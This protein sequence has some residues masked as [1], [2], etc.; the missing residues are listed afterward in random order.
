MIWISRQRLLLRLRGT[1]AEWMTAQ[2]QG[3]TLAMTCMIGR[4]NATTLA[5]GI[6]SSTTN[7]PFSCSAHLRLIRQITGAGS[8]RPLTE[9][10]K[11]RQEFGRIPKKNRR[12][13]GHSGSSKD[14]VINV[15]DQRV[16]NPAVMALM[17]GPG[18]S[19][20][21][22]KGDRSESSHRTFFS[23]YHNSPLGMNCLEPLQIQA[24]E[25]TSPMI[26]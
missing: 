9:H 7:S 1:P 4:S 20:S 16:D 14:E 10:I 22:K 23:A 11:P 2:L 19:S 12:T 5:E 3:D 21:H 26:S 15:D 6:V 25:A 18:S 13:G 8:K 17:N 24:T